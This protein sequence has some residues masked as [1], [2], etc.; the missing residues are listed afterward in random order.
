MNYADK[1]NSHLSSGGIVQVTTHLKSILY[2]KSHAGMFSMINGNLYVQHGKGKNCLSFGDRLL[3]SVRF[4]HI[5][6]QEVA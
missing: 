2:K 6:L 3:V 1:I 4:G 5:K